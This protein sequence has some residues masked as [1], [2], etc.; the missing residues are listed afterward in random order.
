MKLKAHAHAF[1]DAAK[2]SARGGMTARIAE[3]LRDAIAT[4]E[5][6]PGSVLDKRTLCKRFGVSRYPVSEALSRLQIEGLVTIQPQRGSRV[7]LIRLA[8]ARENMFLRRSLE[9][10]AVRTLAA[11]LRAPDRENIERNMRYQTAALAANDRSGFH[12]LDLEFHEI[13]LDALGFP[14]VKAVAENARL[15]L[16]RVR[17][18]LAS[19][20]RQAQTLMEHKR[21]V[22]ALIAG[23]SEEAGNAMTAH[24]DAVTEQLMSLAASRPEIFADGVQWQS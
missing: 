15:G 21:I 16:D 3:S 13:L 11:G 17:R 10:E 12:R 20:Q 9:T 23:N 2:S 18:L 19:P 22:A 5:Y 4:L 24:L 6:A 14:R 7:S 8:D 1:H